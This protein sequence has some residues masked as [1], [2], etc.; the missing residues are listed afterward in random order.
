MRATCSLLIPCLLQVTDQLGRVAAQAPALAKLP[1][2]PPITPKHSTELSQPDSSNQQQQQQPQK[3][4]QQL[5]TASQHAQHALPA[6]SRPSGSSGPEMKSE[7]AV[8]A[9]WGVV[10]NAPPPPE[11]SPPPP[12]PPMEATGVTSQ[13]SVLQ[14]MQCEPTEADA[15]V[16]SI[17]SLWFFHASCCF[18]HM[19]TAS[20]SLTCP[21]YVHG[22]NMA[23]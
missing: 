2:T 23:T 21:C 7:E 16:M 3:Q 17:A 1:P 11:E 8:H 18:A 22:E 15:S 14:C 12:P 6:P 13:V 9:P 19:H 4:A 5:A 10:E 20:K